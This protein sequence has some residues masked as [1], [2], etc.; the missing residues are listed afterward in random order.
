MIK[1]LNGKGASHDILLKEND[2]L[3]KDDKKKADILAEN[4]CG[5]I[6]KEPGGITP[7]SEEKLQEARDSPEEDNYNC[8][9]SLQEL[10]ECLK[11]LPA[12]K[13]TG[14]DEVH[15]SLRLAED[16]QRTGS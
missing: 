11:E 16:W 1:K 9:F 7:E 12:D 13:A 5:I 6:G 8:R 3:I 2:R 14:E 4:L 10:L 15:N